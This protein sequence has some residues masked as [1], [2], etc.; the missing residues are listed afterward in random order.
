MKTRKHLIALLF[1]MVPLFAFS[2]SQK[3]TVSL[4]KFWDNWFISAGGGVQT[5]IGESYRDDQ[6]G[7]FFKFKDYWTPAVTLSV[8]KYFTPVIGLR[9]QGY[10]WS[11]YDKPIYGD[12]KIKYIGGH[13]DVMFNLNNLFG[14]YNPNRFFTITPWLGAGFNYRFADND[15]PFTWGKRRNAS[16]NGGVLLGFRLTNAIDLNLEVQGMMT[17]DDFNNVVVDR[18]YEG[19][20]AATIGLT[21]KFKKRDFEVCQPMDQALIDQLNGQINSLRNDLNACLAK[22]CPPCPAVNCPEVPKPATVVQGECPPA[23]FGVVKFS[24]G[25]SV[26]TTDQ[27]LNVYLAS[28]YLKNHPDVNIKVVGYADKKTGNPTLNLKLSEQRAK[29]VTK[30][31]ADKYGIAQ[32]RIETSWDGDKVQPYSTNEW[33]RVVI[34]VPQK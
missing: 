33:N 17:G 19:I 1:V 14:K 11:V 8:G 15:A 13:G 12:N 7:D 30:M 2:Q 18:S 9:I 3:E 29:A 6:R 21:Y 4:N 31:L 25:S 26:I 5:F 27:Q 32:N 34:F 22:T 23:A 20:A 10:G 28:D 24:I 16:I